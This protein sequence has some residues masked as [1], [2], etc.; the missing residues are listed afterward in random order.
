MKNGMIQIGNAPEHWGFNKK[1]FLDLSWLWKTDN[2]IFISTVEVTEKRKGYFKDL[3]QAIE[4]DGFKVSVPT[5]LGL[6]EGILGKWGFTP[7]LEDDKQLG[8]VEIW[9]RPEQVAA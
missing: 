6:M 1:R 7:K 2:T 3:I 5:P 4:G 9:E 8:P